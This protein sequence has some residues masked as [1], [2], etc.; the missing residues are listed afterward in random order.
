MRIASDNS[1]ALRWLAR[2]KLN[3][4]LR[5]LRRRDN[6]F[7]DILSWMQPIDW[8]DELTLRPA[9]H[10]D[11]V[12]LICKPAGLP[13]GDDNLIVRAARRLA[14]LTGRSAGV[15]I[16]LVKRLP[17]GGGLGGGSADAAATLL[18]LARL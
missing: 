14:A 7:H 3:L 4:H 6:G 12:R 9:A 5:V 1:H 16:H 8:G 15:T 17:I 13:T 18:G 2:G 11:D 10:G